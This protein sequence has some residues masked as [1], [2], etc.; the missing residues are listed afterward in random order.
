MLNFSSM[1]SCSLTSNNH[2][3]KF[4]HSV[5][6]ILNERFKKVT[7]WHISVI[8][9]VILQIAFSHI[10]VDWMTN[11][12]DWEINFKIRHSKIY[13]NLYRWFSWKIVIFH[14]SMSFSFEITKNDSKFFLPISCE[15][16]VNWV[17]FL[18]IYASNK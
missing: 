12:L 17:F 11:L 4:G 1:G 6:W 16:I 9:S 2:K 5:Y 8:H 7:E 3:L 13:S 18:D 10:F 14:S 15:D